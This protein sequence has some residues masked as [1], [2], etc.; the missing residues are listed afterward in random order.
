MGDTVI[1]TI[2]SLYFI[3]PPTSLF[4]TKKFGLNL[5]PVIDIRG[6]AIPM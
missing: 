2:G 6:Q 1:D 3:F 4:M 5:A